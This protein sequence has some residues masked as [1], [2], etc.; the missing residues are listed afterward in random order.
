MEK[1]YQLRSVRRHRTCGF[2]S[3]TASLYLGRRRV[4]HLKTCSD[5]ETFIIEFNLPTDRIVFENFLDDWWSREDRSIH[6]GLLEKAINSMSPSYN[7]AMTVKLR[8]WVRSMVGYAA[9]EGVSYDDTI[10]VDPA[11]RATWA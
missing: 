10:E 1:Q 5:T 8:C 6:F 7:P 2:L 11:W 4:G 3:I 9:S